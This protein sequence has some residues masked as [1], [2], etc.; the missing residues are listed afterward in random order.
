MMLSINGAGLVDMHMEEGRPDPYLIPYIQICFSELEAA[1]H[2]DQSIG[3]VFIYLVL[4]FE[5]G[6]LALSPLQMWAQAL[7]RKPW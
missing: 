7:T 3:Y 4:H 6:E 2:L 5:N 1:I